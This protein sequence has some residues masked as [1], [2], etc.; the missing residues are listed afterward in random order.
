MYVN[1]VCVGNLIPWLNA[2]MNNECENN[3]L[4]QHYSGCHVIVVGMLLHYFKLEAVSKQM[5]LVLSEPVANSLQPLQ[6]MGCKLTLESDQPE[7]M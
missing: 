7:M 3:Q 1:S 2:Y 6:R 4:L 5:F